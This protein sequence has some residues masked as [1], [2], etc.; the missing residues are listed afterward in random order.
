MFS[1]PGV[2]AQSSSEPV[3]LAWTSG[4]LDFSPCGG[5]G[6]LEGAGVRNFL[7]PRLAGL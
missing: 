7:A 1:S 2:T 4:P 5:A 6:R 3:L